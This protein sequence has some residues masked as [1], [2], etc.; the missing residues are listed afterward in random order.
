MNKIAI[1]VLAACLATSVSAKQE[2]MTVTANPSFTTWIETATRTLDSAFDK[3]N[4]SHSETGVTYVRFNTDENGMPQNIATV[5]SGERKPN[6]QRVGRKAVG[7]IRTLGPLFD[8]AK[9][10]M[11]VEAAIIVADDQ[12]QLDGLLAKVNERARRQNDRAAASGVPNPV[13]ALAV[14]SGF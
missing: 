6:L 4:L 12:D 14:V 10:N 9:P 3:V 13:V 7:N 8:G 11:L 2:E 1:A 5:S